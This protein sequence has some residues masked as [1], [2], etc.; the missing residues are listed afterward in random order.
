MKKLET[1]DGLGVDSV[2]IEV[3]LLLAELSLW[4]DRWG[5]LNG[6][7]HTYTGRIFLI[8]MDI[9]VVSKY[10]VCTTICLAAPKTASKIAD[11]SL[12]WLHALDQ[13]VRVL[14]R[15]N[16]ALSA[17]SVEKIGG[18]EGCKK[19]QVFHR[20]SHTYIM[21]WPSKVLLI[22]EQIYL[23]IECLR[24][25]T[26]IWFEGFYSW[27]DKRLQLKSSTDACGPS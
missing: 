24:L 10:F 27:L 7:I 25:M 17:P 5:N 11:V 16:W 13:L 4:A 19:C 14:K 2:S 23:S 20:I 12:W 22:T 21:S 15:Q 3:S 18:K 26:L 6:E 8:E 9:W 1:E